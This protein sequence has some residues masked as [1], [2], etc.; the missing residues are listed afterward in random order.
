MGVVGTG[1]DFVEKDDEAALQKQEEGVHVA[2]EWAKEKIDNF[3]LE[4]ESESKDPKLLNISYIISRRATV[5]VFS[6]KKSSIGDFVGDV[7]KKLVAG[8]I[9]EGLIGLVTGAVDKVLGASSGS[10]KT[11]RIY[12]ITFDELGG[13]NR[14]DAFIFSYCFT[15]QGLTDFTKAVIGVCIVRSAAYMVDDNAYRVILTS[16]ASIGEDSRGKINEQLIKVADGQ[17]TTLNE[18]GERVNVEPGVLAER[19]RLAEVI[20]DGV[21]HSAEYQTRAGKKQSGALPDPGSAEKLASKAT[22][23]AT[24]KKQSGALPE[25]ERPKKLGGE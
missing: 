6:S 7:I 14:L 19:A 11:D 25:A 18:D 9:K 13:L 21:A 15:S 10:A 23:P 3:L 17:K 12:E 1:R 8:D 24:G 16:S 22:E 20:G 5:E 4:I 2:V